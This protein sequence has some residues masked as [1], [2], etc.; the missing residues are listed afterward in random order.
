MSKATGSFTCTSC[1]AVHKK[2]AGRCDACG[3]WNSIIEEAPLSSGPAA[4]S[5][6]AARGRRIELSTLQTE[7]PPPPRAAS[8]MAEFDRV[9]GGGL[10]PASAISCGGRSG[11]RQVDASAAS[12]GE[13]RPQGSEMPLYIRRGSLGPGAHARPT[14]RACRRARGPCRRD[15]PARHPD[16]ARSRT[17]RSC[18]HRFGPDPMGRHGRGSTRFCRSGPR[19]RA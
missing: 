16:H 5:L 2:W 13:F 7:E 6:G 1:G 14:P 11:H 17:R 8:G 3:A 19:R 12:G 9:L 15:E 18:D 4:K 10:V